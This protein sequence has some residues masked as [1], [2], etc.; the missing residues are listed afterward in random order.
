MEKPSVGAKEPRHQPLQGIKEGKGG[1]LVQK[2]VK[3]RVG[4]KF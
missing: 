4:S 2:F 3:L 1:E